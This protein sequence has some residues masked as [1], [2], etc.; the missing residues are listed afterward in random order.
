MTVFFQNLERAMF[1]NLVDIIWGLSGD[2]MVRGFGYNTVT[3][4]QKV[5]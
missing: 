5:I 1:P 2:K 4:G 3:F